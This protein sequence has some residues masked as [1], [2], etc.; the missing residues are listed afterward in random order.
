VHLVGHSHILTV[1]ACEF[2]HLCCEYRGTCVSICLS[3]HPSI[4]P[5][6]RL[7]ICPSVRL[8]IRPS[9][10]LSVCPSILPSVRLSIRPSIDRSIH[11]SIDLSIHLLIDPSIQLPTHLPT[12]LPTYQPTHLST[13]PPTHLPIYLLPTHPPPP[14]PPHP[15]P[16]PSTHLPLYLLA[17]PP[18][19][20]PTDLPSCLVFSLIHIIYTFF[21][22]FSE[23]K[24]FTV[25]TFNNFSSYHMFSNKLNFKLKAYAISFNAFVEILLMA[26]NHNILFGDM[27][28]IRLRMDNYNSPLRRF[29]LRKCTSDYAHRVT[30]HGR[31]E[32]FGCVSIRDFV[33][34]SVNFKLWINPIFFRGHVP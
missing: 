32:R 18:T 34:M 24:N 6:I 13:Y 30:L 10:H 7:S 25:Y 8:S 9:V 22:Y 14:L 11:P 17:Y 27:Y 19:Y 5:S 16:Y 23:Q 21:F 3:I 2:S 31:L 1:V 15:P 4:Y 20:L 12:Y 29:E 28:Y 26:S 33:S